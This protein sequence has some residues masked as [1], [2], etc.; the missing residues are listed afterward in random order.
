MP[1]TAG[2]C[3]TPVLCFTVFAVAP[4]AKCREAD[5]TNGSDIDD[6]A[7]AW[8]YGYLRRR[9]TGLRKISTEY[10]A[11]RERKTWKSDAQKEHFV[12]ISVFL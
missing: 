11:N 1:G 12:V 7:R 9:Q 3:K 6:I 2:D 10:H 8:K 4:S 5:R